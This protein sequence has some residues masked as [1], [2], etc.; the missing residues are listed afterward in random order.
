MVAATSGDGRKH[1][2]SSSTARARPKRVASVG[3]SPENCFS[4][5]RSASSR[6]VSEAI[7]SADRPA[8][9]KINAMAS[10]PGAPEDDVV[11]LLSRSRFIDHRINKA[12]GES[13]PCRVEHLLTVHCKRKR[14]PASTA[15]M[16][17]RSPDS[18]ISGRPRRPVEVHSAEGTST[19]HPLPSGR[20]RMHGLPGSWSRM[21]SQSRSAASARNQRFVIIV[22]YGSTSYA[23][24]YAAPT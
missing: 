20:T 17:A 4:A 11:G 14:D 12:D 18:I 6:V 13:I 3:G 5:V 23:R 24:L 10:A 9:A 16:A 1:P 2:A 7:S 22:V 21:R 15:E 19:Y 8:C